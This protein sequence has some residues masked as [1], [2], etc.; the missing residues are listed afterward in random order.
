V[1][2]QKHKKFKFIK[3]LILTKNARLQL[4]INGTQH[5]S[6][7]NSKITIKIA[8]T[9]AVIG[10]FLNNYR[11]LTKSRLQIILARKTQLYFEKEYIYILDIIHTNHT[12]YEHF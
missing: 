5:N 9:R 2:G 12:R 7:R 8:C 10:T 3:K 4:T 6:I 11:T 1:F